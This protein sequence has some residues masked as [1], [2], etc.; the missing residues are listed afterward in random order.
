MWDIF[1]EVLYVEVNMLNLSMMSEI[2]RTRVPMEKQVI[3]KL[4]E[5]AKHKSAIKKISKFKITA[6]IC[7]QPETE[8]VSMAH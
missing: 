8:N 3:G 1:S 6:I 5:A 4:S 7:K 2:V